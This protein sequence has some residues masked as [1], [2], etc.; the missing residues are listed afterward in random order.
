MVQLQDDA[1]QL[2]DISEFV[3]INRIQSDGLHIQVNDSEIKLTYL[4]PST[5]SKFFI[6]PTL[7][8]ILFVPASK[9]LTKVITKIATH[10]TYIFS[11]KEF[12]CTTEKL[13]ARLHRLQTVALA[14]NIPYLKEKFILIF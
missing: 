14:G 9:V 5:Q 3:A 1:C 2:E 8:D 12:H 7:S 4:F 13:E 10:H 6:F 11:R